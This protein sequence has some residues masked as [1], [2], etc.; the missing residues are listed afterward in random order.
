LL[1]EK[2]GGRVD[3]FAVV[4]EGKIIL[5]NCR[6]AS[7]TGRRFFYYTIFSWG[8]LRGVFLRDVVEKEASLRSIIDRLWGK[9]EIY[10]YLFSVY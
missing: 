5:V 10:L 1:F 4:R 7:P 3:F 9:V 6:P 8:M 2:Y